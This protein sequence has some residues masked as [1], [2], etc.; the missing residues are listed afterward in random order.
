MSGP[1]DPLV[2]ALVT[3]FGTWTRWQSG[4]GKISIH[5]ILWG[6]A[7][8]TLSFGFL[9]PGLSHTVHIGRVQTPQGMDPGPLTRRLGEELIRI[10]EDSQAAVRQLTRGA[11]D[12]GDGPAFQVWEN[13]LDSLRRLY[14]THLE[15]EISPQVNSPELR[16]TVRLYRGAWGSDSV[17]EAASANAGDLATKGAEAVLWIIDPFR[18]AAYRY[19]RRDFR[20]AEAVLRSILDGTARNAPSGAEALA[21]VHLLAGRTAI[22][23]AN[24]TIAE[25]HLKQAIALNAKF[26]PAHAQLCLTLSAQQIESK[27]A[28]A[29]ISCQHAM[30]LDPDDAEAFHTLSMVRLKQGNL[31]E[32][33]ELLKRS[34]EKNSSE[35]AVYDDLARLYHLRGLLHYEEQALLEASRLNPSNADILDRMAGLRARRIDANSTRIQGEK[36]DELRAQ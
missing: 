34:L 36:A 25:D 16:V 3:R 30:D 28:D 35:W 5:L 23:L 9:Y 31:K 33:E 21:Q 20:G 29:V 24:W 22:A 32:A 13:G 26:A 10:R 27:L 1:R 14:W 11:Y 15:S 17:S 4:S 18:L 7:F 2:P 6:I 12:G 8:A 19:Q